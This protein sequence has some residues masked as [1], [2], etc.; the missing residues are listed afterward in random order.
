MSDWIPCSKLLPAH[1]EKDYW[2]CTNDKGYQCL[3][4]WENRYDAY[5]YPTDVWEW[6]GIP[7]HSE[8][9]AWRKLPEPYKEAK[10]KPCPF[11]SADE[12]DL[13]INHETENDG[14]VW[15]WV[16]CGFCTSR[17]PEETTEERA[18][19]EWNGRRSND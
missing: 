5:G 12:R 18:I 6:D 2:V 1:V 4:H 17:G 19:K 16:E 15:Y 14:S 11:C 7:L 10:M 8:V 13:L 9:I 3:A